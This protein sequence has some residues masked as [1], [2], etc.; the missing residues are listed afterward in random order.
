VNKSSATFGLAAERQIALDRDRSSMCKH[1]SPDDNEYDK[2][3]F[4][5]FELAEE[6]RDWYHRDFNPF[7]TPIASQSSPELGSHLPD[8]GLHRSRSFPRT[9]PVCKSL[10][11]LGPSQC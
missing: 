5:M 3:Q 4:A 6:A 7:S 1:S 9:S 8:G 11:H 2:V 10:I